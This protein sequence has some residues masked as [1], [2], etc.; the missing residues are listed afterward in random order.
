MISLTCKITRICLSCWHCSKLLN[1]KIWE[2]CGNQKNR[3][4]ARL[5]AKQSMTQWEVEEH[6]SISLGVRLNEIGEAQDWN[7]MYIY[8]LQRKWD[9][10]FMARSEKKQDSREENTPM[11]HET[12]KTAIWQV[13]DSA[14]NRRGVWLTSWWEINGAWLSVWKCLSLT[15]WDD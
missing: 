1:L 11:R 15:K 7:N 3:M 14:Q 13:H 6:D 8:I 2:E 9:H 12:S 5:S 10:W 4:C